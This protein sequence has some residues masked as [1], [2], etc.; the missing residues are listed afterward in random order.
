MGE[1]K[2]E[3]VLL[4]DNLF[5]FLSQVRTNLSFSKLSWFPSSNQIVA[6]SFS[7]IV[8][9]SHLV[10][11]SSLKSLGWVE[12]LAPSSLSSLELSCQSVFKDSSG[13]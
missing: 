3:K 2:L 1:E 7:L 10:L 6:Y 4:E 12:L 11:V 9:Y 5:Y 8:A 13:R